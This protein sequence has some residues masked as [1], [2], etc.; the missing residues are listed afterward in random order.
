[1]ETTEQKQAQDDSSTPTQ[2]QDPTPEHSAH[3]NATWQ[4]YLDLWTDYLQSQESSRNFQTRANE[5]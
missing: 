5:Q 2:P 3:F 1:M 4:L